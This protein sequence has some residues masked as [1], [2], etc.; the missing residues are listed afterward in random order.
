MK[1]VARIYRDP[2]DAQRAV[3]KLLSAGFRAGDVGVAA[4]LE[5]TAKSVFGEKTV[6]VA[7]SGAS[8]AA[9]G[10]LAAALGDGSGEGKRAAET[11]ATALG[12]SQEAA[13]YYDFVLGAGGVLVAVN[14]AEGK[15]P[16]I[17]RILGEADSVPQKAG[18]SSPGFKAASRMAG[19]N[20]V[21]AAM[22]GDFRKY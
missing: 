1:M 16:E 10:A 22:T 4:R 20:P 6:S 5:H 3:E 21:D 8:L 11:L 12:V 7:L 15:E 14:A 13:E 19:S 17:A 2:A 18:V 9:S